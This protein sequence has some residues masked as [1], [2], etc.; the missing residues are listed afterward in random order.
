MRPTLYKAEYCELARK[1]CLLGATDAEMARF[2][3]VALNTL[4]KWKKAHPEFKDA[5]DQG[6]LLA[7]ANV[8]N[9]LYRRAIG[10]SHPETDIRVVN[11]EIVKTEVIKHYPP[12]TLAIIYFLKNRRK[13]DWRDR[14]EF[15]HTGKIEVSDLTDDQLDAKVKVLAEAV[16]KEKK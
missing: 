9:S 8:A 2:F 7:D 13:V 5:I 16:L 15:E 4:V 3:D 12:E 1:F 6:K 14:Q 10:F 11:G